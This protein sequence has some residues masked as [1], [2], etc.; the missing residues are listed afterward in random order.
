MEMS[1]NK[2]QTGAAERGCSE[3]VSKLKTCEGYACIH[4]LVA[5]LGG[6]TQWYPYEKIFSSIWSYIEINID[7]IL[8]I[9]KMRENVSWKKKEVNEKNK[10]NAA[11]DTAK[12]RKNGWCIQAV[13]DK[14]FYLPFSLFLTHTFPFTLT[15]EIPKQ[16]SQALKEWKENTYILSKYA[17]FL[18]CRRESPVRS[19]YLSS[20]LPLHIFICRLINYNVVDI[21]IVC[22]D[23]SVHDIPTQRI[24]LTLL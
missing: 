8:N 17:I 6:A 12:V 14:N 13:N 21:F 22:V 3:W 18:C 7:I 19:S 1:N 9:D 5:Y 4:M 23:C 16:D 2:P 24:L 20:Y 10:I 15:I 11:R